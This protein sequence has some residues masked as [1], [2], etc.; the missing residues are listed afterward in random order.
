MV[1][2]AAGRAILG[3][4]AGFSAETSWKKLSGSLYLSAGGLLDVGH[5]VSGSSIIGCGLYCYFYLVL[6]EL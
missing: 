6:G 2:V 5:K 3:T 1:T 4:V